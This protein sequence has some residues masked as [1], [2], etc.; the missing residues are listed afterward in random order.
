MPDILSSGVKIKNY[1]SGLEGLT[2]GEAGPGGGLLCVGATGA[3]A[4]GAST[5]YL[6]SPGEEVFLEIKNVDKLLATSVN[7]DSS[8]SFVNMSILGT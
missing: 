3:L 7:F 2:P 5:G 4:A 6:L 8:T 1:F